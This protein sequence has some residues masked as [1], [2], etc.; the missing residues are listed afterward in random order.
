MAIYI[1][2]LDAAN[3]RPQDISIVEEVLLLLHEA[4]GLFLLLNLGFLG[5]E[6][7]VEHEALTLLKVSEEVL[8][9]LVFIFNEECSVELFV[10]PIEVVVQFEEH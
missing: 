3:S 4:N 6:T 2:S 7:W 8:T 9:D 5:G 1:D 10:R